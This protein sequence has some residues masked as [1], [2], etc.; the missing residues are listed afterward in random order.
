MPAPAP[1][2]YS[3]PTQQV[4][5]FRNQ[6][7]GALTTGQ[8]TPGA[9]VGPTTPAAFG[10]SGQTKL[11]PQQ[12]IKQG[13]GSFRENIMASSKRQTATALLGA[14]KKQAASQVAVSG[15]VTG[16]GASTGS[17]G[18]AYT[19][20]GNLSAARN[21]AL[22]LASSYVGTPYVLGGTS[23]KAIDCSGLVMMVYNQL[24][25][26]IT[27]H[28]ATWQGQNIPGVRTS[29]SNLRPGDIVAW[30]NG[31]HIAIYAGNG[32]I[33]EAANERTGTVRRKLWDSPSNVYGIQLRLPGE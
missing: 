18:Q 33:I 6:Q 5:S 8:A 30:K 28:S 16:Q 1:I 23:H 2:T 17:A 31:E 14:Q 24:G 27:R 26:N 10:A 22:S 3:S 21:K 4:A 13:L 29:L 25:Y 20:Q 9:S 7:L 19:P 15:G 11:S 32:E 12:Q